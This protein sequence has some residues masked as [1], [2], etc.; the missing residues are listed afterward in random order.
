MAC[1]VFIKN[2]NF[3]LG[4]DPFSPKISIAVW[5]YI[6]KS[7]EQISIFTATSLR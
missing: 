3:F 7:A 4:S 2:K 1:T 6:L 5:D